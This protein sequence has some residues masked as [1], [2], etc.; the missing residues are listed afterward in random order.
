MVIYVCEICGYEYHPELG[1]PENGIE[2]NTDF[3]DLPFVW[4]CPICGAGR[5]DFFEEIY[6][7][8]EDD[9]F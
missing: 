2:E 8:E 9:D 7:C 5:E 4:S 3:E 1:D 6:R